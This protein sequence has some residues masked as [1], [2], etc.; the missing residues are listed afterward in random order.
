MWKQRNAWETL[1]HLNETPPRAR[2]A[3]APSAHAGAMHMCCAHHAKEG[4][5]GRTHGRPEPQT[6]PAAGG[7]D[8]LVIPKHMQSFLESAAAAWPQNS[9]TPTSIAVGLGMLVGQI[10]LSAVFTYV[11][12]KGPWHAEP[13]FT[14][15]QLVYFPISLYTTYVGCANYWP[16]PGTPVQR[17]I[18]VNEAGLHLSQLQ[19]AI[20]ILWDI[21][22]GLAVPSM[23]DPIMMAHHVGFAVTAFA[24]TQTCN[25]YYALCFFGVVEFSSVFLTFA[26]VFHPKHKEYAAWLELPTQRWLKVVNDVVRALF[27][28]AYMIVRGC[29]FPYTVWIS[30]TSDLRAVLALPLAQR[31]NVSDAALWLPFFLGSAFSVL[32]L[33][34]GMLLVK[35]LRKMLAG[36]PKGKAA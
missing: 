29:F 4:Q 13:G 9:A 33:Y 11:T 5:E 10:L 22:V 26:D 17:L 34:W 12:K 3:T 24:V 35:Q 14:A 20:L 6:A 36:P 32:Q 18:S 7:G 8:Y 16:A 30:Y 21:P 23:R 15:H 27:V 19:L 2:Q 25:T 28:L 31:G 1:R